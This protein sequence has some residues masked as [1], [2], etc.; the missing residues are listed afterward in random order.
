MTR[1]HPFM[2]ASRPSKQQGMALVVDLI[3]LIVLTILG[4]AAIK[5]STQQ[6]RM[7]ASNMQQAQTFQAADF[8][9]RMI[10]AEINGDSGQLLTSSGD[11]LTKAIE[12]GVATPHGTDPG[13]NKI[14]VAI[15]TTANPGYTAQVDMWN[16]GTTVATGSSLGKF[17][18]YSF[19]VRSTATQTATN[20]TST[21]IQGVSYLAPKGA[22]G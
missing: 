2:N 4:V 12:V 11:L 1:R 18:A 17:V 3:L 14:T 16:T 5:G 6:G 20:I 22:G 19:D 7:A 10:V 15:P 21:N 13:S 9:L 8:N